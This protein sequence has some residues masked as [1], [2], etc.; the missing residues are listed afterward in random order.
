VIIAV[1][2]LAAGACQSGPVADIPA[3]VAQLTFAVSADE[4]LGSAFYVGEG[5]FLTAAHVVGDRKSVKLRGPAELE[6]VVAAADFDSDVALMLGRT[7]PD[8]QPLP[9]AAR[10]AAGASV[11]AIGYPAPL[12]TSTAT[13][14]TGVV[15]AYRK[16][17]GV[18]YIQLDAAVNPGNSGGPLVTTSGQLAG[19]V[20][21]RVR[22]AEGLGFALPSGALQAFVSNPIARG[23]VPSGPAGSS[24]APSG[25]PIA[26]SRIGD[27]RFGYVTVQTAAGASCS[28]TVYYPPGSRVS[29]AGYG[30]LTADRD[31]VVSWSNY[32]TRFELF[33]PGTGEHSVECTDG[34]HRWNGTALFVVK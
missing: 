30:K 28:L 13:V 3:R 10:L 8:V 29:Q 7:L 9:Y 23:R 21:A 4:V 20:L 25:L 17:E 16:I 32:E 34:S 27:S 33:R 18:E 11:F 14:T 12:D 31:G 26:N 2:T 5:R 19:L 24:P 15:S 1:V 22:N 6:V